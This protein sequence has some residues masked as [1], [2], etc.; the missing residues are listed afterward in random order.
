M[1]FITGPRQSGKTT[2]AQLKLKRENT[3]ALYYL[4]DLRSVRNRYKKNELFFTRERPASGNKLWACFDEIHKMPKWKNILKGVYDTTFEK[5][6]FI[7][8]G[9][10]KF[11]ITRRAGDSLSGRYF[12]FHLFPLCLAELTNPAPRFLSQPQTAEIFIK[13][14]MDTAVGS[15]EELSQLLEYGG[16]PEPFVRQ[17][18]KFLAKWS[19][20][21]LDTVIKEDIGALTRIIDKEYIYDLYRLL[22]EMIGSPLSESSLASHLEISPPTIKNYLKRL[23]DFHLAFRVC[24]YSKNIKRS[25]L[26]AAK[27]YLYDWTRVK[28]AGQR[29]ENYAAV[30]LKTRVSLW[31]DLAGEHYSLFYIRNKQRQETDFLITKNENP[32]LLIEVKYS[33]APISKHHFETQTMLGNIPLIQLCREENV[34]ALQKQNAYRISAS[35]FLA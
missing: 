5:Y 29:F 23:E 18:K 19:R 26:K 14:R 34:C 11:D 6:N 35:R 17:S 22:P 21:Y 9:S 32:W 25:L 13:Q 15:G 8:T 24:P 16:F 10:A 31:T 27:C 3:E 12:T 30:D 33:D 4:W 7:I 1:R 20:D 2:L 28:D